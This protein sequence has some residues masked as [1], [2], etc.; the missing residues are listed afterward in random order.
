M[1]FHQGISCL[2]KKRKISEFLRPLPFVAELKSKLSKGVNVS[3]NGC[4]TICVM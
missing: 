4:M 1:S 2:G 3:V